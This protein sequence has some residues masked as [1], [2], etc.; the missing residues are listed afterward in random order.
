[1]VDAKQRADREGVSRVASTNSSPHTSL[2]RFRLSIRNL[3][4]L[5]SSLVFFT[6]NFCI[7]SHPP[8]LLITLFVSTSCFL[9]LSRSTHSYELSR[10]IHT[11]LHDHLHLD[12]LLSP[13]AHCA[14][15]LRLEKKIMFR[16]QAPPFP[17]H[18]QIRFK[19]SDTSSWV[20]IGSPFSYGL[21]EGRRSGT[22]TNRTGME[23]DPERREA[24]RDV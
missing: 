9:A 18:Q 17:T 10:P 14:R 5:A 2:L 23:V 15:T 6:F 21:V 12:P 7:S 22:W 3:G 19:T 11:I 8:L 1:M 13:R 16:G 24:E 20:Y 4:R